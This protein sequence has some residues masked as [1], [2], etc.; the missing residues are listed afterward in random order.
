MNAVEAGLLLNKV[1]EVNP[2]V[3][4][5]TNY[6]VTNF[7]ANGLLALGAS[8]V[9][10]DSRAEVEEM[11]AIA[12]ALVLNIGTLNERTA[13]AMVLAGKAANRNG[14][15]VVL[16]PVAAGVTKL[17]S[18]T[19]QRIL[20]EV[21][22]SVIR[23]NAAEIASLIGESAES[24][25]VDAGASKGNV[26]DL[27]VRAARKLDAIIAVTGA[28]DY[29]T[30]GREVVSVD[31]GDPILT[32]VTGTGCL[33]SSSVAAFLAIEKNMLHAASA[34]LAVYGTAA[35]LAAADTLGK[36]P[37][38]F[39]IEFINRLSTV[40]AQDLAERARFEKGGL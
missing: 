12:G 2:L 38:S 28:T 20:K 10:A 27:A 30:D 33:L 35:E 21:N 32:K 8:P 40:T 7:T 34:A 6:V 11:A 13:E 23:G 37:G 24:K 17:R 4:N 25:G 15:P 5:I 1:R 36:G 31:N 39:Q 29:I 3:H 14:I 26:K 19:A 22:V 16:D 18:L 9:M